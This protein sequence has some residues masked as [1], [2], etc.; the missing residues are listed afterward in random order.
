MPS[1]TLCPFIHVCLFKVRNSTFQP[2]A[3]KLNPGPAHLAEA[4]QGQERV[5]VPKGLP[6][7]LQHSRSLFLFL[8]SQSLQ[9][10]EDLH[11]WGF[12]YSFKLGP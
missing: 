1:L 3:A 6:T 10:R 8:L 9:G 11:P 7:S 5:T 12:L 2:W 4:L